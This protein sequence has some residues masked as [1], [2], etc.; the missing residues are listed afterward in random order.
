MPAGR[1]PP[2]T[3]KGLL[4][5]GIPLQGLGVLSQV[6]LLLQRYSHTE[7][8]ALG[9]L[10]RRAAEGRPWPA[11]APHCLS[12]QRRFNGEETESLRGELRVTY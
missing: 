1:R 4:F 11:A 8:Q 2:G 10:G 9:R 12:H 5:S 3:S 7:H 6:S